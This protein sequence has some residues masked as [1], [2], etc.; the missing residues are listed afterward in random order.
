MTTFGSNWVWSDGTPVSYTNWNIGQPGDAIK[1]P[2]AGLYVTKDGNGKWYSLDGQNDHAP[3]ICQ[4]HSDGSHTE[5][6]S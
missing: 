4:Y 1:S 3:F 6:L 2:S 5:L